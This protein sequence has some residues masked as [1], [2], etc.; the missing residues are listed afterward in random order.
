MKQKL[1][2]QLQPQFA[3][4]TQISPVVLTSDGI[5]ERVDDGRHPRQHGGEHVQIGVRTV[6]VDH[7]GKHQRQE[8][9]QEAYVD[10][11]QRQRQPTVFL[12]AEEGLDS[13]GGVATVGEE[14]KKDL[15]KVWAESLQTK[16]QNITLNKFYMKLEK[17]GPLSEGQEECR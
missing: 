14:G 1:I 11:Q 13:A 5:D 8:A 9:N 16:I 12:A 17:G 6:V 4:P 7:V 10:G 3:L 2:N 15:M